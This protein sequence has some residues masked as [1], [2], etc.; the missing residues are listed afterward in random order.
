MTTSP[1]GIANR[2]PGNIR[3]ANGLT[4]QG[5]TGAD[6]N[7]FCIFDTPENGLRALCKNLLAYES[8]HGLNTVRGIIGRW[9]PPSENDTGAYVT[10]VAKALGVQ[11]DAKIDVHSIATL[12]SLCTAIVRHE[13]GQQPY[14]QAT[15]TAAVAIA[16]GVPVP[17]PGAVLT[18]PTTPAPVPA[19]TPAP[20]PVTTPAPTKPA[21]SV[22][23]APL[24][25]R[26]EEL[27]DVP[28]DRLDTVVSRFKMGGASV[29]FSTQ[30]NGLYR[31]VATY[32]GGK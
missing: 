6:V 8:K 1:L 29:S 13:N 24:P 30:P 11:P 28:A 15:I 21:P 2:N 19:T 14:T 27:T 25:T 18:T 4:W 23:K 20:V 26:T 32:P 7:G 31:V 5:Q 22:T 17:A 9:A 16:L 12:V 3:A 10:V